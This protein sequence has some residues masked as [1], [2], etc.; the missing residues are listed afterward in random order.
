MIYHVVQ[1][2]NWQQ[3]LEQGYYEAPSLGTEGFIHFSKAEQVQGVLQRYYRDVKQL[4][5][6][7]IDESKLTAELKYENA[8]SVNE[9]FPHLFGRLNL[10]AVANITEINQVPL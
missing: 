10:D 8:T 1:K 5:L 7:H 6:L 2:D 4:L 9:D 3:A